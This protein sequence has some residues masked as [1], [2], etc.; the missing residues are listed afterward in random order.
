ML[1]WPSLR[2]PPQIWR[3]LSSDRFFQRRIRHFIVWRR[4]PPDGR[5]THCFDRFS[6]DRSSH[7]DWIFILRKNAEGRVDNRI[8]DDSRKQLNFVI[9]KYLDRKIKINF[10]L[11]VK[12]EG[13]SSWLVVGFFRLF[14]VCLS[15][16]HAVNFD[17]IKFFFLNSYF[18]SPQCRGSL[19][20][21]TIFLPC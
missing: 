2:F 18:L 16:S 8:M 6:Y 10:N 1:Q 4:I 12:R 14:S 20:F 15:H 5:G 7:P 13:Y 3:C 9:L 11:L 19:P 17:P 21:G